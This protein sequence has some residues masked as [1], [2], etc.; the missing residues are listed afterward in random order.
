MDVRLVFTARVERQGVLVQAFSTE[1]YQVGGLMVT[2]ETTRAQLDEWID[3]SLREAAQRTT[4]RTRGRCTAAQRE[5]YTHNG[6]RH[7]HARRPLELRV[8]MLRLGAARLRVPIAG[9]DAQTTTSGWWALSAGMTWEPLT[10]LPDRLLLGA[11]GDVLLAWSGTRA[12]SAVVEGGLALDLLIGRPGSLM[13]MG[14]WREGWTS[15]DGAHPL[16]RSGHPMLTLRGAW[17][18]SRYAEIVGMLSGGYWLRGPLIEAPHAWWWRASVEGRLGF[19][20]HAGFC[21]RGTIEGLEQ[22][23]GPTQRALWAIIPGIFLRY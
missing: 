22:A 5:L 14:G 17:R 6:G 12:A 11:W 1:L 16:M 9:Q 13:L 7:V 4:D 23:R 10:L 15:G 18:A 2:A 20:S 8:D 19:D 21:V 3:Y